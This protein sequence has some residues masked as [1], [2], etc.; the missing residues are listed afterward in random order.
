MNKNLILKIKI[1]KSL[2]STK[3]Y[4]N[5]RKTQTKFIMVV[6]ENKQK[7]KENKRS[8]IV[9]CI[10]LRTKCSS[11]IFFSLASFIFG[12]RDKMQLNYFFSLFQSGLFLSR[13]NQLNKNIVSKIALFILSFKYHVHEDSTKD[14]ARY[15]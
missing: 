5:N 1:D 11:L 6:E 3:R 8:K 15:A 12:I 2:G 7:E 10:N 4:E 9:Y 13:E 14:R